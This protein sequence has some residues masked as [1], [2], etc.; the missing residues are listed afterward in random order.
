MYKNAIGGNEAMEK[1]I[2]LYVLGGIVAG[3]AA[4][5]VIS[6]I[7]YYLRKKIS[8]RIRKEID[9]YELDK[10][11]EED[12]NEEEEEYEDFFD[13]DLDEDYSMDFGSTYSIGTYEFSRK[14]YNPKKPITKEQVEDSFIILINE[15]WLNEGRHLDLDEIKRQDMIKEILAPILD[16]IYQHVLSGMKYQN[17][18]V[19]EAEYTCTQKD[20][21]A[22]MIED[23]AACKIADINMATNKKSDFISV[24]VAQELWLVEDGGFII[25]ERIMEGNDKKAYD[26]HLCMSEVFERYDLNITSEELINKI[27]YFAENGALD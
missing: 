2:G 5:P 10:M 27:K 18:V 4:I 20:L 11:F 25:V 17:E 9:D 3:M 7:N 14:K 21:G 26:I 6:N 8:E 24:V 19:G 22:N 15:S 16:G 1:K 13:E 23:M 12:E